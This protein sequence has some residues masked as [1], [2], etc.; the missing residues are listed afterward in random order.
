M[1]A[2]LTPTE[3][4]VFDALFGWIA[5]ALGLPDNTD[6][7]IKG[8]QNLAATPLGSYIVISPG[9]LQRQDFGR[10]V[11]E[12]VAG[13]LD[14]IAHNT[15]SY[16]VDCYGQKGAERA[17]IIAGAWRTMWGVDTMQS[18]A[19]VPLYADPAQQLNIVNAEGQFEQRFMVR[20]FGQVNQTIRVPQ[21]YFD[22]LGLDQLVCAD[23]LP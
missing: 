20:L 16:Q 9:I 12:P 21:D 2:V 19:L 15:Y 3:D 10:R 18:A 5:N 17:S 6:Q 1:S 11:Y 23:R 14:L 13:K 22:T 8:F 7:I 4:Q